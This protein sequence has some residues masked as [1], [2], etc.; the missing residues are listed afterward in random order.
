MDYFFFTVSLLAV[1]DLKR[2]FVCCETKCQRLAPKMTEIRFAELNLYF[3]LL[4][5][6]AV[7]RKETICHNNGSEPCSL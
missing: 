5:F 1:C 2:A 4:M 6:L 3:A 7:R